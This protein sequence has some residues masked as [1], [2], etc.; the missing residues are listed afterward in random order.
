MAE[1]SAADLSPDGDGTTAMEA[2]IVSAQTQR[3]FDPLRDA[4]RA[5]LGYLDHL[6]VREQARRQVNASFALQERMR[7]FGDPAAGRLAI[8]HAE[9]A[10]RLIDPAWPAEN[11]L[12]VINAAGQAYYA[13]GWIN[14]RSQRFAHAVLRFEEALALIDSA[15]NPA[16][17]CIV[18]NSLANVH[19]TRHRI[20]GPE[21][22]DAAI[23]IYSRVRSVAAR[24]KLRTD[25]V[26]AATNILRME[27]DEAE[28]R[29]NVTEMGRLSR[30]M[31]RVVR[32]L[33]A[34][35]PLI[36]C[37]NTRLLLAIT[38]Q[39]IA[40]RR[41][42]PALLRESGRL[43]KRNITAMREVGSDVEWAKSMN[44]LAVLD[45]IVGEKKTDLK[46][47]Q[48]AARRLTSI[49]GF[50]SER[51]RRSR[52]SH[53]WTPEKAPEFYLVAL[54]NIVSVRESISE[55]T[56]AALPIQQNMDDLA[57]FR[58]RQRPTDRALVAKLSYLE[59]G[60]AIKMSALTQ[61]PRWAEDA[62][63]LS[64]DAADAADASGH[65]SQAA[66]ALAR[67]AELMLE[68]VRE[69]GTIDALKR[70][71]AHLER[72]LRLI[73]EDGMSELHVATWR[74]QQAVR[75]RRAGWEGDGDAA[76]SILHQARTRDWPAGTVISAWQ[77]MHVH[78]LEVDALSVIARVTNGPSDY[79]RLLRAIDAHRKTDQDVLYVLRLD[80]A[81]GHALQACGDSGRAIDVWTAGQERLWAAMIRIGGA[82]LAQVVT[83]KSGAAGH[84]LMA[85]RG[86]SLADELAHALL[87]RNAPGDVARALTAI[88]R[89]RAVA[90]ALERGAG[91]AASTLRNELR[92]LDRSYADRTARLQPGHVLPAGTGS[93]LER[94]RE[95]R[96]R[97]LAAIMG[98]HGS[99]PVADTASL[100]QVLPQ[101]AACAAERNRKVA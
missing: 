35:M 25:W 49:A 4:L 87:E 20:D 14:M 51:R 15:T 76:R 83:Y 41:Y 40:E 47:H 7:H 39:R 86:L 10:I 12:Y 57:D 81:E 44:A 71:E 61:L 68:E 13:Y 48:R 73:D 66:M 99:S 69:L 28:A 3:P 36:T 72:A 80:L 95:R 93:R 94:E 74:L 46:V 67:F 43:L 82:G 30:R 53:A 33:T 77:G 19:A 6:D 79:D 21:H 89:G 90:A 60:N 5:Y 38:L 70:A 11:R 88:E 29:D 59:A 62:E 65:G 54:T 64:L 85:G 56:G 96:R 58:Q 27:R 31:R 26:D 100:I 34:D 101:G 52:R 1:V 97:E 78:R 50:P 84:D 98:Q 8:C 75:L 45:M 91:P 24:H 37:T 63:R 18:A 42:D 92:R 22:R 17:W 32:V 23:T 16:E 9:K 55:L 2:R